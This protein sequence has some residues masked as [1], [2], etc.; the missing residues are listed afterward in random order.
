MQALAMRRGDVINCNVRIVRAKRDGFSHGSFLRI[1]GVGGWVGGEEG[2]HTEN[3][4]SVG[5]DNCV[6]SQ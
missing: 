4:K 1:A 5:Q 2:V 3:M 6:Q